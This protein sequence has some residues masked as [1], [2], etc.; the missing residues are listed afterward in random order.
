MALHFSVFLLLADG[1][2]WQ[3]ASKN[4]WKIDKK[5]SAM[6]SH[7]GYVCWHILQWFLAHTFFFKHQFSTKTISSYF[8]Q[9]HILTKYPDKLS[10][11]FFQIFEIGP[12]RLSDLEKDQ[13]D[14]FSNSC[15]KM[16]DLE[17]L[18]LFQSISL[19]WLKI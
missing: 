9:F 2:Q 13:L 5:L 19:K 12:I 15:F 18:A 1:Q 7:F 11:L 8:F 4:D 16:V 17:I 6:Y 10:L 3:A 14:F